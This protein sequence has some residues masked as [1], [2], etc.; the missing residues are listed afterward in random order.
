[1]FVI[2]S[3]DVSEKRVGK[4]AKIAKKYLC[5]IQRSVYNG[6]LTKIQLEKMKRELYNQADASQDKIVIYKIEDLNAMIIDEMGPVKA[7]ED[8]II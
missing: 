7:V 4:M 5:P 2:L 3:Y 8:F 6:F 1:M